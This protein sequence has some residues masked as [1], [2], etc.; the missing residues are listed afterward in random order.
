MAKNAVYRP[1]GFYDYKDNSEFKRLALLFDKIYFEKPRTKVTYSETIPQN[2]KYRDAVV[3]ITEELKLFE[4]LQSVGVITEF[5]SIPANQ[6][7]ITSE[8]EMKFLNEYLEMLREANAGFTD[9][10]EA[11]EQFQTTLAVYDIQ[12]RVNAIQL[13]KENTAEFYPI[14][15]SNKTFYEK[16]R[17]EEVVHFILDQLPQPDGGTP[18]EKIIEFRNDSNAKNKYY[19][20]IKWMNSAAKATSF[21]DFEEEFQS[22][23]SDYMKYFTLYDIKC[24]FS[25]VEIIVGA[26]LDFLLALASGQLLPA[27]SNVLKMSVSHINLL[28]EEGKIPGREIAYINHANEWFNRK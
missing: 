19:S 4:Y 6:S 9:P 5:D 21:N 25:K 13:S 7:D 27:F 23:Q 16:G 8:S 20:L 11:I 3:A 26:G 10:H 24:N 28:Q 22:L 2:I 1:I 17:K 14:L 12:A 18:W 15:K